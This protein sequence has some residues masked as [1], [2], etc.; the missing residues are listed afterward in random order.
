MKNKLCYIIIAFIFFSETGYSQ[1][2]NPLKNILNQN[3]DL[4]GTILSKPQKNEIQILYT[5]INRDKKNNAHFKTYSYNLDNQH[6]FYPAS[7]VKLP[8]AIFALEKLNELGIEGL[9]KYTPL[10]IDSAF[11]KQSK[12]DNDYSAKNGKASIAHYIKKILLVSDNDA[13]NRLY[14]FTDRETINKK[15]KNYGFKHSRIINRLAV[16]DGEET[17]RHTNPLYFYKGDE[18]I[19]TKPKNYDPNN[20]PLKLNNLTRG[21]GYLDNNNQLIKEPFDFTG[22]NTFQLTDQHEL[23]K[24]LFFPTAFPKNKRFNLTDS[25]YDFLYTYMSKYPTESTVPKY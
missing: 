13:F 14:E 24:R 4:F 20:Y 15:L 9:N 1:Q 10:K 8:V 23:M 19:Y 11:T 7:T 17:S 22:K 6:Y 18:V 25:D 3:S 2:N 16:G 21:K 5:Q 12:V